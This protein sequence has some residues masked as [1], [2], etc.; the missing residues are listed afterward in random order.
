MK[1]SVPFCFN[2][3]GKLFDFST[4]QVMAIVNV[5]PDS[6][7]S[8]SRFISEKEVLIYVEKAL[9]EGAKI[10]DIGAY[11]T[12]P[13]ASQISEKE[14]IER[15]TFSL[16]TIRSQFPDILLSVDTFRSN[17]AKFV[18]NEFDVQIINDVSGGTLDEKMF[19]TVAN[20]NVAY[21]LMHMRGTSETMLQMTDYKN[22]TSEIIHFFENRISALNHLGVKDIII[23]PGFGFAKTMEQNYEL[24]SKLNYFKELG[25]PILVGISRKSMIYKLLENAP[26]EALNGTTA[27]NTLALLNG[28]NILRVHD[29]KEAVETIKIVQKYLTQQ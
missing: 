29:V 4:P 26:E 16:K 25:F 19:E 12:R 27:L 7:Y 11:S 24:L 21:V 20:L 17:V 14:E 15:L 28:A 3:R 13:F 22:L 6:F 1:P 10:I 8:A 23:D 5:T 9:N 2:F 18:V